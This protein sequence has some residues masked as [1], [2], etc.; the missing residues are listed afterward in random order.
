MVFFET[1]EILY[2]LKCGSVVKLP[3]TSTTKY[4]IN[5]LKFRGVVLWNII[6]KI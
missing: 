3:D 5:S 2:N 1:H 4:G 6:P